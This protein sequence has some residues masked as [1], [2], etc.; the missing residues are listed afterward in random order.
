MRGTAALTLFFLVAAGIAQDEDRARIELNRTQ[1]SLQ[2]NRSEVERLTELRMRH[3]LG[4]PMT[5]TG[6]YFKATTPASSESLERLQLQLRQEDTA[7]ADLL[8][9]FN[10]QKGEFERLRADAAA[11]SAK[12]RE[13]DEW[14][15]V[16]QPGSR[17]GGNRPRNPAEQPIPFAE[18]SSIPAAPG[19]ETAVLPAGTVQMVQNLDS[20]KAKIHGSTDHSRVAQA[21]YRAGLSRLDLAQALVAQGQQDAA[22]ELDLKAKDLL[23]R[24]LDELK[25]RLTDKNPEFV[26]LFY[27]GKCL[28]LLFKIARRREGLSL[29][30]DAAEYQRREQQVREPFLQIAAR[31]VIKKG[32]GSNTEVLGPWG[33]AA[34]AAM[35][36]FRW[37]NQNAN[38]SPRT[39]IDS[40]TWEGERR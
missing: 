29:R 12:T 28:E 7:T 36:H 9:R 31:D 26:D 34:Q 33:R 15:A 4:L 30:G 2:Q 39:A 8:S 20:V 19:G 10:K 11:L 14:V 5:D 22:A 17:A 32:E 1:Q 3:D 18:G 21:L 25:P 23:Q 40:I 16:P 35:E 13:D 38:Y 24:A 37:M 27:Q 6:D